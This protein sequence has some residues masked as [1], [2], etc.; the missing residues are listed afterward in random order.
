ML[1]VFFFLCKQC[2]I[3]G[4]FGVISLDA[5][6]VAYNICMYYL[7]SPCSFVHLLPTKTAQDALSSS[8]NIDETVDPILFRI[9]YR[10]CSCY[11]WV[12]VLV[13]L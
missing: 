10:Y 2:F 9:Q 12:S 1:L 5:H 4:S 8:Y 13:W 3:A 7:I 6:T 11:L